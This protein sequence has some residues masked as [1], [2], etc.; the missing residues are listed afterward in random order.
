[1]QSA[2]HAYNGERDSNKRGRRRAILWTCT[3]ARLLVAN[4]PSNYCSPSAEFARGHH[5]QMTTSDAAAGSLAGSLAGTSAQGVAAGFG[6]FLLPIPF[7]TSEQS[8]QAWFW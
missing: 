3:G 7:F 8:W 5:T 2:K 6:S 4:L 1:M